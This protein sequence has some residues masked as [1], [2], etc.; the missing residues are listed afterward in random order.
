M[1]VDLSKNRYE[2][3]PSA[4]IMKKRLFDL[5]IKSA[6]VASVP[7]PTMSADLRISCSN[8][9]T[10]KVPQNQQVKLTR[11]KERTSF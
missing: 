11:I 10:T 8:E 5:N 9:A 7:L 1:C 6:S 3:V 2:E 4:V